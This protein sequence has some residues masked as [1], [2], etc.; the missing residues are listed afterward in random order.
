MDKQALTPLIKLLFF[1]IC[2]D[3]ISVII[4]LIA[5]ILIFLG[6]FLLSLLNFFISFYCNTLSSF[7]KIF[8]LISSISLFSAFLS[9][10]FL[11][12]LSF[13]LSCFISYQE[14]F[15][16]KDQLITLFVSRLLLYVFG[17][18][19]HFLR[20]FN[21]ALI[22]SDNPEP[23]WIVIAWLL[24]VPRSLALTLTIPLASISNLTSI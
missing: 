17:Q 19:L 18:L 9:F 8:F 3:C 14:I 2:F 5:A 10:F 4:R 7:F 20:F 13:H 1:E 23:S 22:S 21:H 11:Q 24:P 6:F 15:M 12:L 16:F